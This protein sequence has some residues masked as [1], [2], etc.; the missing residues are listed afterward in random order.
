[1][2]QIKCLYVDWFRRLIL[3]MGGNIGLPYTHSSVTMEHIRKCLWFNFSFSLSPFF[4]PLHLSYM[5]IRDTSFVFPS[6]IHSTLAFNRW[7][8]SLMKWT[9]LTLRHYRDRLEVNKTRLYKKNS[10]PT[11]MSIHFN[12]QKHVQLVTL[13]LK[14]FGKWDVVDVGS[15]RTADVFKKIINTL[16][17]SRFC[18]SF[19]RKKVLYY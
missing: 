3:R 14:H 7:I 12:S 1:M 2:Y 8:S 15:E 6:A 13:S 4:F 10:T 18:P 17:D 9:H 11:I 5:V 16:E 19:N